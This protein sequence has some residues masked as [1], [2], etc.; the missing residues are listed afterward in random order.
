M[1]Y[2]QPK[3]EPGLGLT[4][5]KNLDDMSIRE[6]VSVLRIAYLTEDFD[7]VEEVLVS[8]DKRLHTDILRLQE[9]VELEILTRLQAEEDLR[10]RGKRAQDNYENLLKEVK[11]NTNL[12]DRETIVELRK[13][14][15]E[16]ELEVCELRKLKEKWV[17]D[18]NAVAQLRIRV[19]VLENDNNALRVKNSELEKSMEK[20]SE[21]LADTDELYHLERNEP[22]RKRTKSAQGALS[23]TIHTR[24]AK[25]DAAHSGHGHPITYLSRECTARHEHTVEERQENDNVHMSEEND[26]VQELKGSQSKAKRKMFDDFHFI[27]SVHQERYSKFLV[28]KKFVLEKKFQLEGDKF[29][30]I[31]AMIVSRGWVELTSFAKEASTKLA[32]EFFANAYQDPAKGG[33]NKNDL[34]KFTSFVRGKNVPFHDKVINQLFGLENYELCSFEAR[35]A[36]GSNINHQEILSTLCRPEVDWVRNKDGIPRYLRTS[37]LTPIA[38]TWATFV[39]HTLLSCSNRSELTV[40]KATFLTAIVKGEPVNVGRL[41]ADSLWDTANCSS[42]ISYVNHASLIS[43][44]CERVGVYPKKNEEMVK[45]CGPI[46]AKWIEKNCLVA[47]K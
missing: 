40:L 29:S 12:S 34:R 1:E 30:D 41:L 21:A 17:D 14:K 43:K 32:K 31:H 8:R 39:L 25:V 27:S 46:T 7:R 36:K 3:T 28:N 26:N 20:N 4:D 2:H 11:K 33:N 45:P 16:L 23:V 5:H 22:A 37:D 44:L 19:D 38:K 18:T 13:K 47:Y 42:S 24:G 15:N 35:M 9:M 10:N 6:L